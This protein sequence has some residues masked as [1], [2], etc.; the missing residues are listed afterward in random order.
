MANVRQQI[1]R[2]EVEGV[3]DLLRISEDDAFLRFAQQLLTGRSLH[4][5]DD[6]DLRRVL[7]KRGAFHVGRIAAFLW[8]GDDR[9]DESQDVLARR[10]ATLTDDSAALDGT[11]EEAFGL[12]EKVLGDD[13]DL[14]VDLDRA[15]KSYAL[16]E[17]ISKALHTRAAGSADPAVAT[18]GTGEPAA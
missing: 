11:I 2:D 13:F 14:A 16:D 4:A 8:K 3:A 9:W 15:L 6:D 1:I 12:L 7:A 5:F 17:T 18:E 10:I